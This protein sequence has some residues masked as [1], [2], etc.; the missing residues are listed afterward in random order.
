M[1]SI[2]KFYTTASVNTNTNEIWYAL[3]LASFLTFVFPITHF[4]EDITVHGI[5]CF[6]GSIE[7]QINSNEK[8]HEKLELDDNSH[9]HSHDHHHRHHHHFSKESIG[10]LGLLLITRIAYAKEHLLHKAHHTLFPICSLLEP[11]LI[12]GTAAHWVFKQFDTVHG[13]YHLLEIGVAFKDIFVD[14]KSYTSDDFYEET[15]EHLD[16]LKKWYHTDYLYEKVGSLVNYYFEP[17]ASLPEEL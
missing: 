12:K 2:T 3:K 15:T 17:A 9:Q 8:S 6:L 14:H 13:L 16:D 10:L 1:K 5:K 7:K 11:S 4:F